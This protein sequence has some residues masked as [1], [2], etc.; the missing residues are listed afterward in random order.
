MKELVIISDYVGLIKNVLDE[1]KLSLKLRISFNINEFKNIE[2]YNYF[3]N[4][5]EKQLQKE[6]DNIDTV[7]ALGSIHFF[8]DSKYHNKNEV[9]P[10]YSINLYGLNC[11]KNNKHDN[12]ILK[13][14]LSYCREED[15]NKTYDNKEYHILYNKKK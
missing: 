13:Y 3:V 4:E 5:F 14:N 12:N 6:Y 8:I 2:E 10:W 1:I 7:N 15:K 9:R 11:L